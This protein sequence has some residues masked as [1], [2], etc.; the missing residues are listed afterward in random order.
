M[1]SHCMVKTVCALLGALAAGGAAHADVRI[2]FSGPLSGPQAVVGQDQADGFTLALEQLGGKLGGQATTVIKEDD[3]LKPEIGVQIVRKFLERDRVDAIV[4]LGYS[5]VLMA[6]LRRLSE[7]G[8]P[9][10]ATSAGPSP[11]AGSQCA[12]NVF[13]V[14]FQNDGFGEAIGKLMQEKG[15]KNVY[16]MAPNYQAGKD[17]LAGFKRFYKGTVAEEVYTQVNQADYSAEITQ[18]QSSK[19]DALFMFYTGGMGVNFTKQL[20][21]SGMVGKLPVYS[22]FTVDG[23]NLPA[24][25]ESA[26]GVVS[27]NMWDATLDNP[28]NARFVKTFIAKYQ[29]APSAYAATGYDAAQLLDVAVRKVN[30][31]VTDK[32]AFVAAV[33][34]AGSEFKSVRGPFKFNSNNLPI[35]DYYAFEMVKDDGQVRGKLISTPL[36]DHKDAYYSACALK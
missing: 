3:Q 34:A 28:E 29:R 1:N 22:T 19:A 30:G 11:M 18:L 9:A 24:L 32:P 35:Q 14:S 20:S 33:K 31:K 7:S 25:R 10:I 12:A 6:T 16:L 26:V 4:G 23:A 2:G 8:I 17:M 27:G 13:S 21:Q 36:K 15:Y 5:N